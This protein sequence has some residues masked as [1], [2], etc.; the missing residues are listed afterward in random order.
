MKQDKVE[1]TKPDLKEIIEKLEVLYGCLVGSHTSNATPKDQLKSLIH[2]L[3]QMQNS[4]TTNAEEQ[5]EQ[6]KCQCKKSKFTRTVDAE[7]NPLCGACG[8]N[9]E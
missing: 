7:F 8:K 6:L 2:D 5:S 9:L 1:V 3:K 4:F